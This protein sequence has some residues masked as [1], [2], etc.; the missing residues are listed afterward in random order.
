[1]RRKL[2]IAVLAGAGGAAAG[3]LFSAVS[4][5]MIGSLS[6]Q[7]TWL[8]GISAGL[9]AFAGAAIGWIC[10]ATQARTGGRPTKTLAA[11]ALAFLVGIVVAR[12]L[13]GHAPGGMQLLLAVA[14]A[15]VASLAL[16]LRARW[17][18]PASAAPRPPR[19]WRFQFTLATLL[20]LLT[21]VSIGMALYVRGPIRRHQVANEIVRTGG[22]VRY[23]TQ[24]PY[25]VVD[26]LG[27]VSRGFFNTVTE[28]EMHPNDDADLKQLHIF[29]QL[30]S[31]RLRGGNVTDD[32]MKFIGELR[33]LDELDLGGLN[34]TNAALEHIQ[35]LTRLRSLDLPSG[36]TGGGL[37]RLASL[38]NLERLSFNAGAIKDEDLRHL[39]PLRHL[40]HL[41]LYSAAISDAALSHVGE[42]TSLEDLVLG[43]TPI[44][45]A[46]LVHLRRLTR[47]KRLSLSMASV[48]DAGLKHLAAM[49]QLEY[50]ELMGTTV[51]GTGFAEL[52]G[53]SQLHTLWLDGS[54]VSDRGLQQIGRLPNL[55]T[56]YTDS[57]LITD[58]GLAGLSSLSNLEYLRISSSVAVTDAGLV[59]LECL[60]KL[61]YLDTSNTAVTS[62]GLERWNQTMERLYGDRETRAHDDDLE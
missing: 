25:W 9:G 53:L 55:K 44:T 12:R 27:D 40:K 5:Q 29:S 61:Q 32:G 58:E 39:K 51:T 14:G 20:T 28:I 59:H 6:E 42:L 52:D 33:A 56:L 24:A 45:D 19:S 26:L 17:N 48:T 11:I 41:W 8:L 60:P 22:R 34:L 31:L 21:L 30:R 10:A 37:E 49:Q 7:G 43:R 4:L 2:L 18:A 35:G 23:G 62:A 38:S 16:R 15:A 54:P 47:L 3:S 13:F 1:M 46:G 36:V 50:L 57:K